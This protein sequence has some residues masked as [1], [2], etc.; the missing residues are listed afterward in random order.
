[1]TEHHDSV[2]L[3]WP[4]SFPST[5]PEAHCTAV[6]IGKTGDEGVSRPVLEHIVAE[7]NGDWVA[8]GR[9]LTH[10]RAMFGT[11]LDVPVALL[12][13]SWRIELARNSLL[14]QLTEHG[15]PYSMRYDFNPHVT[16]HR[17]VVLPDEVHLGKLVLWWGDSRPGYRTASLEQ[18]QQF[19]RAVA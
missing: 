14:K 2:A 12:Y 7:H 15:I 5:D 4:S 17:S 1:M 13:Y 8:P 16:L 19:E 3:V 10:G 6:F 18:Y 11:N 9:T